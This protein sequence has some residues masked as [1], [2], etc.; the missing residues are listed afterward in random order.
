MPNRRA[1]LR[2]L[3]LESERIERFQKRKN[4]IIQKSIA[5]IDIDNFKY[6]NERFGH[7]VGD[8]LLRSFAE[9]LKKTLRRIDFICRYGGDEFVV[10]M[11]DTSP[12]EA[13]R[14][15]QRLYVELAKEDFF[16]SELKKITKQDLE[17][18]ENKKIG[19][20]MGLCSNSDIDSP[21]NLT[22][23]L[24]NADKALNYTREKSKGSVSNWGKIKDFM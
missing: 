11:S 7:I 4:Q 24:R 15:C 18:P 3:T 22:E 2:H 14:M 19:F 10:V 12:K 8:F 20:S 21:E 1:L 6:Y 16:L 5:Y 9:I 23:V 13:E 17:I